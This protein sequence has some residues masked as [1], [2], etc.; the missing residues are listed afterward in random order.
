MIPFALEGEDGAYLKVRGN[1]TFAAV[2][3][4]SFLR[5]RGPDAVNLTNR[6][7]RAHL[8]GHSNGAPSI[9]L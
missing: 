6:S 5:L 7:Y 4:H 9:V 3:S 1:G 2:A 8:P